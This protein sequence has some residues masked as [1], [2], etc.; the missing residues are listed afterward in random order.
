VKIVF[1]CGGAGK[2]MH[3]LTEDKFMLKFLGKTLLKHQINMAIEAGLSCFVIVANSQNIERIKKIVTGIPG[4][5][6]ET[7]VQR[8]PL[9][10]ANALESARNYLDDE[11]VLVNP[12]D[13]FDAAAYLKLQTVKDS[14]STTSYLFGYKVD[15]YFPG[16]YM[17]IDKK[18]YLK[19]IIEKPA[20]GKEPSNIVN[21]LIHL[22]RDP[23][24]LLEYIAKVTTDRDDAYECAISA[25]AADGHNIKT[26]PLRGKWNAIKYPWHILDVTERFLSTI[27]GS[28][29]PSAKIS[30]RAILEG[31][32]VVDYNA[33]IMENA[34][35]RGPV[36]IGPHTVV[37]TGSIVRDNSHIGAHC[38]IGFSTEVKGSYIG[39]HNHFHMNYIGD[40][41]IGNGCNFG[42][43][44]ILA[45][46]RFDQ[47]TVK[48]KIGEHLIDTGRIKF[49]AI[50]GNNCK[51]GIN[52]SI[53]P[54]IK[55]SPGSIVGPHICISEDV[56]MDIIGTA[57]QTRIKRR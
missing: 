49:G 20:K 53:M 46:Y 3:P 5:R 2:R 37:G 56:V 55:I 18:G 6:V 52:T 47:G 50:I 21:V 31:Q 35:I 30:K 48:V 57:K 45:N 33:V 12:N 16:G 19:D 4:I 29:S 10:I 27:R 44:T 28:I 13:I 24:R 38:N 43:G 9:G 17:S 14:D 40:S 39:D 51:T 41:I 54:G 8:E 7:A 32:V 23:Q 1:I 15:S 36:Y 22:H 25:M 26:L 11:I 34:V 42:A